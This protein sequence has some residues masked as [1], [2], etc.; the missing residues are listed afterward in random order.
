VRVGFHVSIAGSID[1]AVDRAA[2]IGCTTFQMFT[3]NPRGWKPKKLRAQDVEAFIEKVQSHDVRPVFGHMPYLAN[4]ASPRNDVYQKSVE[5]LKGELKR[6]RRLQ[7]PFL[8]THLG[9][10]LGTGMQAGFQRIVNAIDEA[11]AAF[12]DDVMLLLENTAGT[13]N[14]MGGSFEDIQAIIKRLA[15][16]EKVG[17]CFD[18]SHAFAAGY[19]LRNKAAVEETIRR[20]DKTIGSE[21][22]RLIHLNDS[23]GDLNSHIDRHEHLGLGKIGDEGFRNVLQSKLGSLPLILETPKDWRR[24]DV[25]NLEKVKELAGQL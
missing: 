22:L 5:T 8:V 19:D 24:S 15:Q 3:R 2:Q 20:F 4:L 11:F 12:G 1:R 6:C 10:H 9:S 18:T 25:E 16:P 13:S 23:L 17:V 7:I 14:S 21:K